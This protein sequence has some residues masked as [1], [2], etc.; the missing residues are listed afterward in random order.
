MPLL[1]RPVAQ[2]R[3]DEARLAGAARAGHGHPAARRQAQ[4]HAV[5][6]AGEAGVVAQGG[7]GEG[8]VGHA[9]RDGAT[10]RPG[11]APGPA[12][13]RARRGARPRPAPPSERATASGTP[14]TVSKVAN[15]ASGSTATMTW[16]RWWACTAATPVRQH[17]GHRDGEADLNEQRRRGAE[18]GV[19]A[20]AARRSGCRA[21]RR[22]ARRRVVGA[23]GE[24]LGCPGQR[25]DHLGGERAG[26][27]GHLLVA[28]AAPGEQGGHGQGDEQRE[29]RGPGRPRGG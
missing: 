5:E 6:G 4:A 21:P 18:A 14:G 28:A 22:R 9:R 17:G 1:E 16:P 12:R 11:R 3:G 23:E 29:R 25:V 10:G 15:A 26:E 7:V 13:P 27:R 2:E 8:D 24:Q 20:L 19:A